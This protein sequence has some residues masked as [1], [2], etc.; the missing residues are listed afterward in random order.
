MLG[1]VSHRGDPS[2]AGRPVTVAV[3]W[4]WAFEPEG[5]DPDDHDMM[6]SS[7]RLWGA[8]I[9]TEP[10]RGEREAAAWSRPC[11]LGSTAGSRRTAADGTVPS[12]A[13]PARAPATCR[14][15]LRRRYHCAIARLTDRRGPPVSGTGVACMSFPCPFWA[16][17]I[18]RQGY[19]DMTDDTEASAATRAVDEAF[20][21]CYDATVFAG[22]QRGLKACE[23]RGEYH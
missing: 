13:C 2:A 5:D 23:L 19:R 6:L 7:G 10:L 21:Q 17:S 16:I 4:A 3:M 11:G 14:S 9:L 1:A 8:D 12:S 15:P 20:L 22:S 18:E